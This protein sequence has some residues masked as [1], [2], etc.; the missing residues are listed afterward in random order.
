MKNTLPSKTSWWAEFRSLFRMSKIVFAMLPPYT[1]FLKYYEK[2]FIAGSVIM[3]RIQ[4]IFRMSQGIIFNHLTYI[5]FVRYYEKSF[6]FGIRSV[7]K[8]SKSF[9]ISKFIIFIQPPYVNFL[10]YYE[11]SVTVES[12]LMSRIQTTFQNVEVYYFYAAA[13]Y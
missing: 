1:N 11:K 12:V 6:Y 2:F 8:F 3:S 10:K 13:S 7:M 9:R 4:K 5:N